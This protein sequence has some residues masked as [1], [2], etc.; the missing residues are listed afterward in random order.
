MAWS[1]TFLDKRVEAEMLEQAEDIQAC[2]KRIVFLIHEFG[3][4]RL[5]RSYIDHLQG[6]LWEL[7][8]RGRDG[9]SELFM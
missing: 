9:I 4:E 8:L 5:P 3:I 7:R 2:F 6:P 1:V